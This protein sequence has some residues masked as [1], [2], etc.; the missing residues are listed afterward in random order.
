MKLLALIPARQ[1]SKRLPL[2]NIKM[3]AGKPLIAWTIEAALAS[4]Y[5]MDVIVSTDSEDIAQIAQKY[6]A[7]VPFLRPKQWASDSA[8]T[9]D[10]IHHS[11][12]QLAHLKRHYDSIILLQATSP[13]RNVQHI[14]EAIKLFIQSKAK[15]IIS[16][17]PLEHPIEWTMELEKNNSLDPFINN[18]PLLFKSRSQDFAT[19]YRLNGAIYCAQLKAVLTQNTFYLN[20]NV[21]A[22]PMEKQFSVDIDDINDFNYAQYLLTVNQLP[23]TNET[24]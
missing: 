2:K 17:T 18:N 9:F 23:L 14:D 22:Y 15:S 24:D 12:D 7:E 16:V 6:G 13:V 5:K 11:I 21:Y 20:Q 3:C 19:R 8:S 10:V 4:Q 1:G